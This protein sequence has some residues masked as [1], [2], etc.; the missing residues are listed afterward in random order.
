MNAG[1]QRVP[2][3]VLADYERRSLMHSATRPEQEQAQ[4]SWTGIAFRLMDADLVSGIDDV[5]EVLTLPDVTVVP[6]SVDWVLGIAN[7]RGNLVP[8]IDLRCF[9]TTEMTSIS[10]GSRVLVVPQES[11]NVGV[12]VD[13]VL[14]Q[15]HFMTEDANDRRPIEGHELSVYAGNCFSRGGVDWTEFEV[16]KL[17]TDPKFHQAAA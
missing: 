9:L 7:V 1:F 4:G 17:V 5:K 12:L 14:G 11:G 6:G 16:S 8:I 2:Y 10:D 13:E 15:R 3:E